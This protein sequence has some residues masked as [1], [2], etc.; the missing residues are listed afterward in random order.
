MGVRCSRQAGWVMT[1][2]DIFQAL[3]RYRLRS[4]LIS[5]LINTGGSHVGTASHEPWPD[6]AHRLSMLW[7]VV[8]PRIRGRHR[9][10][11]GR[12]RPAETRVG[13]AQGRPDRYPSPLLSA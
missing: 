9:N 13:P 6:A 7:R 5:N 10:D 2:V 1:R 11:R 12:S 3:A 4:T 8:P